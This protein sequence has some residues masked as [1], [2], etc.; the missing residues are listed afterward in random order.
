MESAGGKQNISLGLRKVDP[1]MG[2]FSISQSCEQEVGG[3]PVA[4]VSVGDIGRVLF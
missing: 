1:S 3:G 2:G 4:G